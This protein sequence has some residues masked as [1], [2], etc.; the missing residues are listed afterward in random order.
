[1]SKLFKFASISSCAS[2][3]CGSIDH[4]QYSDDL[5]RRDF[6]YVNFHHVYFNDHDY[7]YDQYEFH[8]VDFY[9]LV[10]NHIDYLS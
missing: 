7:F 5:P 2:G 4:A 8:H 10:D 6:E 9:N 3:T 1:M